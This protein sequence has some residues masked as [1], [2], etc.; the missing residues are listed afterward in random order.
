MSKRSA[1]LSHVWQLLKQPLKTSNNT[2]AFPPHKEGIVSTKYGGLKTTNA[3][4]SGSALLVYIYIQSKNQ[5]EQY[6]DREINS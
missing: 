4:S 5:Y 1:Y 6:N 3:L 2:S